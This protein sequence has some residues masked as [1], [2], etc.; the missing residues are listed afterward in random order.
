MKKTIQRIAARFLEAH[1][2]GRGDTW[3]NDKVRIHRFADSFKVWDLTYAGKRGKK[4]RVLTALPRTYAEMKDWTE[5]HSKHVLLNASGGYDSVKKYFADID[6][7]ISETA[8]RGIDVRPGDTP[9][10]SLKWEAG[11]D[12]LRLTATPQE[13]S[14]V[15]SVPLQHPKTGEPLPYRQDTMYWGRSRRDAETFYKWLFS[16][17]AKDIQKMGMREIWHIWGQLNVAFDSH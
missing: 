1:G 14:L 10:I 7:A 5:T 15:S 6:A 11:D 2:L 4:V 16:G 8:E 9:E 13:F 12:Q 17:G 3:E